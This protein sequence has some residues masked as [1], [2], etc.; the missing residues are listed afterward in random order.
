M[1]TAQLFAL[2]GAPCQAMAGERFSP[3]QPWLEAYCAGVKRPPEASVTATEKG[4]AELVCW[5]QAG[6]AS[7]KAAM[8]HADFICDV[9]LWH[10]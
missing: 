7:T 9:L 3:V 1:V 2:A 6:K 5:A 4:W 10:F 8:I